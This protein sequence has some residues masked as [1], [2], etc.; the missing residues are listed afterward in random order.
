MYGVTMG[1]EQSFAY[2]KKATYLPP[3]N[4]K[5]K[6]KLIDFDQFKNT[7][8]KEKYMDLK[9]MREELENLRK[10]EFKN[11]IFMAKF[12]KSRIK[13]IMKVKFANA[14]EEK[15]KS[16]IEEKFVNNINKQIKLNRFANAFLLPKGG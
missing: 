5:K 9:K 8:F 16:T 1:G 4:E 12:Q 3:K 14:I 10:H 11:K 7:T 13:H 15:F 6:A 2:K